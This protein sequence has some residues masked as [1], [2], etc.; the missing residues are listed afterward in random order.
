LLPFLKQVR[1]LNR[2]TKVPSNQPEAVSESLIATEEVSPK[3]LNRYFWLTVFVLS[4]FILI[5]ITNIFLNTFLMAQKDE[6]NKLISSLDRL[7][8]VENNI[9]GLSRKISFYKNSLVSRKLLSE[10]TEFILDRIGPGLV[11]NN[12]RVTHEKFNVSLT[13]KNVYLFTRL[14]MYYLQDKFVSEIS[15]NSANYSPTTQEFMVELSGVFK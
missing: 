5:S 11:V 14:I 8:S 6:Q 10:K 15:I 9:T 1:N 4:L 2:E 13:G 3:V 12:A 7:S